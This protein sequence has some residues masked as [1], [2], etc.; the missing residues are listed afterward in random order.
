MT[1]GLNLKCDAFEREIDFA[2]WYSKEQ[3]PDQKSEPHFVVGEAKSF[4]EEAILK[5]FKRWQKHSLEPSW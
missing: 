1:T 2:F 5:L 4:A 3:R